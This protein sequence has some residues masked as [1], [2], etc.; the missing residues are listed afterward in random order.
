M[1]RFIR[2]FPYAHYFCTKKG[3]SCA[4]IH[5]RFDKNSLCK[6]CGHT[7]MQHRSHFTTEVSNPIKKYGFC[8]AGKVAM[9][10]L[11][12]EVLDCILLRRTK[13]ERAADVQL[14]ELTVR[15]RQGLSPG[16]TQFDTY[17]EG[18]TVLHNYAHVFDLIMR[19]RQAVDHPYLI[20]HGSLKAAD[21]GVGLIPSKSHGISEVCALCQDDIEDRS[22]Q[23][24]ASCGHAF[25]RECL[26]ELCAQVGFV[27]RC[28]LS[29]MTW[30]LVL[31]SS[32]VKPLVELLILQNAQR[33]QCL[34]IDRMCSPQDK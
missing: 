13:V 33:R 17:V 22:Q 19:L 24:T 15:I 7:K 12:S 21:P 1:I 26:Q 32:L 29:G 3:C 34:W 20:V 16:R 27:L 25:H 14:P 5:Y 4:S 10:K 2:F 31:C 11:R 28:Y 18:G 30:V 8:G 6:K 9:E 23:A